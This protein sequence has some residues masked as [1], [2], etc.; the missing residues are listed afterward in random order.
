MFDDIFN[1]L[2]KVLEANASVIATSDKDAKS[3]N[4]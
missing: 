1:V 2:N 3:A 4:R